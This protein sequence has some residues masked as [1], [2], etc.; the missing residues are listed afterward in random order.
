MFGSPLTITPAAGEL[1]PLPQ[2]KGFVRVD[3]DELDEE[4][5]LFAAAA[6]Q[7]VEDQT[8]LRLLNQRVQVSADRFADLEHFRVGPIR[9]VASIR[10]RD[11]A[12]VEQLLDADRYELQGAPL[13]Q[14]LRLSPGHNWPTASAVKGAIT[15]VLDVGY[16]EAAEEVPAKLRLAAYALF[17]G[18]FDDAPVDVSALVADYRFWL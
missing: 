12:G 8:G 2:A 14:G 4:L 9:A 16:G 17:R 10:Y 15:V 11:G 18:R 5:K 7:D 13:E 1:I 6:A 3:G